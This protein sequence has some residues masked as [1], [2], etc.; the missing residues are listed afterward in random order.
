MDRN[1]LT[2]PHNNPKYVVASANTNAFSLSFTVANFDDFGG[3]SWTNHNDDFELASW[4]YT[5]DTLT[6]NFLVNKSDEIYTANLIATFIAS[7]I[8]F[9]RTASLTI[10]P[11]ENEICI[12]TKEDELT[13]NGD[14]QN[15]SQFFTFHFTNDRVT[16][17]TTEPWCR[18]SLKYREQAKNSNVFSYRADIE[19]DAN[20]TNA[21][22]RC[23]VTIS[24]V[25][26]NGRTISKTVNIE[27]LIYSSSYIVTNQEVT[28]PGYSDAYNQEVI[29]FQCAPHVEL[30]FDD[31]WYEAQIADTSDE[32]RT[33]YIYPSENPSE[34]EERTGKLTLIGTDVRDLALHYQVEINIRQLPNKIEQE[35]ATWQDVD[36]H[37]TD[38]ENKFVAYQVKYDGNV[39]FNGTAYLNNGEADLRVNHIINNYVTNEPDVHFESDYFLTTNQLFKSAEVLVSNGGNYSTA[40]RYYP[41]WDSSFDIWGDNSILLNRYIHDFVDE[42]AMF[43]ITICRH[44]FGTNIGLEFFRDGEE[45]T[46]INNLERG[47]HSVMLEAPVAGNNINYKYSYGSLKH[48]PSKRTCYRYCLYYINRYGGID[49]SY[50]NS[51]SN[52]TDALENETFTD[53]INNNNFRSEFSQKTYSQKYSETYQL[54]SPLLNDEQSELFATHLLHSPKCWLQDLTST[55]MLP[56]LI[57]TSQVKHT[58]KLNNSNKPV[59]YTIEVVASYTKFV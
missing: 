58:T 52:L 40:L 38:N 50:F 7:G 19:L 22:R 25:G 42:R 41:R 16:A 3:A 29:T 43:P 24:D 34:E 57:K 47:I 4:E 31:D 55:E 49:F 12:T 32:R 23:Q 28:L 26:W 37:V 14:K 8:P 36:L 54:K 15:Y 6:L 51:A 46:I 56:C 27:Q 48:M 21:A 11:S 45:T 2:A 59:Q 35:K 9:M 10:L 1:I 13:F 5:G 17:T 53:R 33:L 30:D 39:V 18:V 20:T 44:W